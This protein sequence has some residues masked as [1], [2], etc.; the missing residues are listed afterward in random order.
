M[1]F[2]LILF[3]IL[4]IWGLKDGEIYWG[5]AIGWT[6]AMGASF[7]GM[8]FF[9]NLIIWFIIASVLIDI[10]LILRIIGTDILVH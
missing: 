3:L 10:I 2:V 8:I 6:L 7:A 9:P 1:L 5:E 4:M